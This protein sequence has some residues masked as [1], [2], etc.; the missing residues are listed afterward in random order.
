MF[1]S[2]AHERL[3][4]VCIFSL[5]ESAQP[6]FIT[7]T[8]ITDIMILS[9]HSNVSKIPIKNGSMILRYHSNV[10]KLPIKNGSTTPPNQSTTPPNQSTTPPN[11]LTTPPNQSINY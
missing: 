9:Y 1:I 5:A 4:A 3:A 2:M 6:N 11:Q 8:H 7:Q 10:S